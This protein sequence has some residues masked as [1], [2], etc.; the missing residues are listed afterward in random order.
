MLRQ[1]QNDSQELRDRCDDAERTFKA[2][3]EELRPLKNEVEKLYK[4]ALATTNGLSPQDKGFKPFN[5]AFEKLPPTIEEIEEDLRTSQAK[6]F[7]MTK[8]DD[9]ENV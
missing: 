1:K 6:V 8:N 4:E 9:S 7:C 3:E 2:L 5:N